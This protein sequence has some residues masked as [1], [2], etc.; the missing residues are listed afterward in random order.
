MNKKGII[1][2]IHLLFILKPYSIINILI[3]NKPK[4]IPCNMQIR[5]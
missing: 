5:Q 1:L 4:E 2:L 3:T